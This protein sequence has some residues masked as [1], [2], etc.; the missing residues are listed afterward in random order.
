MITLIMIMLIVIYVINTMLCSS[1]S[2]PCPSTSWIDR[3]CLCYFVVCCCCRLQLDYDPIMNVEW[4][5]TQPKRLPNE[6]TASDCMHVA[7]SVLKMKRKLFLRL[8]RHYKCFQFMFHDSTKGDRL[9]NILPWIEYSENKQNNSLQLLCTAI[10]AVYHC[11][12]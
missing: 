12:Y 6:T 9:A 5:L 11:I 4:R 2:T 8:F 3:E 1:W 7:H 10:V